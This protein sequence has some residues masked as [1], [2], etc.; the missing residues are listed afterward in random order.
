M[1][2]LEEAALENQRLTSLLGFVQ[3]NGLKTLGARVIGQPTD[4]SR[5]ITIDRGSADGV[6]VA[7]PVVGAAG[8]VGQTI[9]VTAHTAQVR[10][11]TDADSGVAALIQ[12]NRAAGIVRGSV[13]GVLELDFVGRDTVVKVGDLVVTSGIGGIYPKGLLIGEV[14]KIENLPS[15][16]YQ[17]I[18]LAPAGDF[19]KLEEVLVLLGTASSTQA[20]GGK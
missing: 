18:R 14:T 8:V 4:Y 1:A 2:T 12:T 19:S 5:V 9:E 10:L 3:T 6:T 20:A 15:N 11:I 16:L 17:T 7:M 13:E